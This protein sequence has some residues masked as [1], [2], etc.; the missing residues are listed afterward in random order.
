MI[1]RT[2]D[3]FQIYYK[4]DHLTKLYGFAIPVFNQTLTPYFEN[5]VI[6]SVVPSSKADLISV[7]S[8]RL[9]QKRSTFP[10]KTVLKKT[11]F[12]ELTKEQILSMEFDVANLTP[13]LPE[14]KMLFMA[15]HWHGQAW[16]D[17]FSLLSSFLNENLGIRIPIELNYPIY[18]NHFIAKGEIYHDYVQSC[19]IPAINFMEGEK[20]VFTQ[21]A[22]YRACK[23]MTGDIEATREYEKASGRKD[24][25]IGVFLLER[26]FSIWINEKSLRVVN[27]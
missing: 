22:G 9:K 24:W 17:S 11:G 16:I 5:S 10:S 26:L 14:H 18:G 3:F 23:E 2:L 4:E 21:D 7:A 8:W 27:I 25:M 1:E 12:F 13:R 6:A 19:L 20:N 15:R